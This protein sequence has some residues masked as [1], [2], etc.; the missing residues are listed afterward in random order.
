VPQ[1]LFSPPFEATASPS[2]T[3]K[4]TPRAIS[5]G[6]QGTVLQ[7]GSFMR[8]LDQM[9]DVGARASEMLPSSLFRGFSERA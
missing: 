9:V 6:V 1:S 3:K 8:N 4:S 5:S 2:T 7:K